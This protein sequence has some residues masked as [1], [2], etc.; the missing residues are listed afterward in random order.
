LIPLLLFSLFVGYVFPASV[1][2]Y[3][4]LLEN[5]VTAGIYLYL[6]WIPVEAAFL[7]SF[8]ATPAKWIFGIRVVAANGR[9][10]RYGEAVKRTCLVWLQGEGLGIPIVAIFTRLFAY[11]RLT[12]TGT[13]LWDS[14]TGSV[15]EHLEWSAARAVGSV[16]SVF[17]AVMILASL[18][19]L[20]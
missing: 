13:T 18:N 10:L 2:G 14:S 8:G 15:V 17:L 11:R 16:L 20:S 5:P 9:K 12:K 19:A 7:S 6:L 1:E 3:L 4:K